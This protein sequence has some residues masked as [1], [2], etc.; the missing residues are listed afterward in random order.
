MSD[1]L[2]VVLSAMLAVVLAERGVLLSIGVARRTGFYDHPGGYKEHGASTPYLG[3]AAVLLALLLTVGVTSGLL[4]HTPVIL[5]CA[6]PLAVVGTID[7]RL[8]VPP[9]GRVAAEIVAAVVVWSTGRGFTAFHSGALD[10]ALTIVWVVG[11]VNAFNLFDNLDGACASMAGVS[12]LG[13]G[14]LGLIV[15]EWHLAALGLAIAGACAGFLRHNLAG[16]ARIFLG[17]GGSMPL[18]FMI[19]CLAMATTR[20]RHLGVAE[21]FACGLLAGLP[22]LDTTLVTIS[23]RRRGESILKGGRDHLTHRLLVRLGTARR[24]ALALGLAQ[25]ALVGLAVLGDLSSHAALIAFGS[26][27]I[28]LGAAAIF[29]LESARWAPGRR[30]ATTTAISPPARAATV[31]Q[32]PAP[33]TVAPATVAVGSLDGSLAAPV[34]MVAQAVAGGSV[35]L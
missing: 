33:A 27:A 5:L 22:V 9:L 21:L 28:A 31:G 32:R 25:A 11:V 30:D 35:E 26:V 20:G 12:A 3:G 4:Y 19:A 17:D 18:G 14:V 29:V 1:T 24:V 2:A 15:G 16:P 8:S 23:R 34:G 13:A 7:D 10:L 6:V